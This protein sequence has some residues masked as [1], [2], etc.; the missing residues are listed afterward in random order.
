LGGVAAPIV[1]G[2]V[3]QAGG[4]L[5]VVFTMLAFAPFLSGLVLSRI[6]L[7]STGRSL[8]EIAS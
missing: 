4:S 7:E 1:V 6:R 2:W 8:E 3:I 5:F